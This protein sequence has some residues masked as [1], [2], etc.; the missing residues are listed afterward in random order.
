MLLRLGAARSPKNGT[1][2]EAGAVLVEDE[3]LNDMGGNRGV[4][5]AVSRTADRVD[6]VLQVLVDANEQVP[7]GCD[8]V[9]PGSGP[10]ERPSVGQ[11]RSEEFNL[12]PHPLAVVV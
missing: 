1:G 12:S 7:I 3:R 2:R 10:G 6:K 5:D 9:E 4:H 11:R 8:R